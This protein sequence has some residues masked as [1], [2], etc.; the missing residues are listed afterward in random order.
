[1]EI[2]EARHGYWDL[3]SFS[4]IRVRVLDFAYCGF[5]LFFL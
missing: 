4:E 5:V 1:M 3:E 2:L